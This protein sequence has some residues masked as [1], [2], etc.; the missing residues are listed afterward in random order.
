[1]ELPNEMLQQLA[2]IS[3]PKIEEHI[4]FNMAESTLEQQFSQPLQTKIK[5][6]SNSLLSF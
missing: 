3:K 6:N 1:M 2:F 5:I 4:L